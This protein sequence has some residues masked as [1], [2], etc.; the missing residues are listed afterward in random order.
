MISKY[1]K[2][3]EFVPEHIYKK[4]GEKA[5]RFID[6]R[7]ISS[8]D[9][10]K[11]RFPNGT[12]TLNNYFWGGNRHWSGI[13]TSK[14]PDYSETSMHSF[15]SAGDA[16]FSEYEA[17]EIRQDIIANP[18]IYPYIKGIEMG[19]SWLHIDTRNEDKLQ[20]FYPS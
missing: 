5:W 2:V 9:T 3:H 17:E 8:F 19:I 12:V 13:R 15:A 20:L 18:E 16:V 14:S 1:Y 11:E 6:S 10:I 7:L 4:Y